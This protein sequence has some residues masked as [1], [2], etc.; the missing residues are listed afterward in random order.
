MKPFSWILVGATFQ[1]NILNHMQQMGIAVTFAN[2]I[3]FFELLRNSK[4]TVLNYVLATME[5]SQTLTL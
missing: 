4:V 5:M 2:V 3:K 1:V